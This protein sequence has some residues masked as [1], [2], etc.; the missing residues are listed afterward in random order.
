MEEKEDY[1]LRNLILYKLDRTIAVVG[2]VVIG[3]WALASSTLPPEASKV[4]ASVISA[5]GVYLGI[6]GAK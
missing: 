3:I 2:M 4:A 1:S 6:K 5:L